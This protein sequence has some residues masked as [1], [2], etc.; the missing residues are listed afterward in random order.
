[1]MKNKKMLGTLTIE[2]IINDAIYKNGKIGFC[3]AENVMMIFITL[4]NMQFFVIGM[5]ELLT[6]DRYDKTSKDSM[7]EVYTNEEKHFLTINKYKILT[8]I[9][10]FLKSYYKLKGGI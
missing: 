6:H 1:M 10:N 5:Y 7:F 4:E 2:N 9:N 3:D 8:S